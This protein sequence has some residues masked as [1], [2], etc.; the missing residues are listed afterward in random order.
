MKEKVKKKNFKNQNKSPFFPS[1]RPSCER[2]FVNMTSYFCY[3]C[4]CSH[5]IKIH[6]SKDD[7]AEFLLS[8]EVVDDTRRNQEYEPDF[9]LHKLIIVDQQLLREK[10][11]KFSPSTPPPPA[12]VLLQ[13]GFILNLPNIH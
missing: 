3:L 5:C 6:Q 10:L 7:V 9:S 12:H 4:A 11:Y 1:A 13:T 2:A 8:M